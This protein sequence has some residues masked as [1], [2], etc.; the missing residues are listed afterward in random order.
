[1]SKMKK[2]K[3]KKKKNWIVSG[4][5]WT[6]EELEQAGEELLEDVTLDHTSRLDQTDNS[7]SLYLRFEL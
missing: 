4:A 3:K 7:G 1:M 5:S 2:K 6:S